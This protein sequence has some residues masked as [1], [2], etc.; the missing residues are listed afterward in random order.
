MKHGKRPT[1]NQKKA[2]L[3]AG[4]SPTNWLVFKFINGELHVVH[5][6]T[7]STKIILAQ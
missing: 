7:G 2:L 3:S 6:E 1:K 5:R 4:L